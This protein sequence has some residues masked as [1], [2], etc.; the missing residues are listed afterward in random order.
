MIA[1]MPNLDFEG[2][3]P[4]WAGN[5][6][7]CQLFNSFSVLLIRLEP[8]MNR[9]M[10]RAKDELDPDDPLRDEIDVF[11]K[12]EANH[13][14]V[15][16]RFNQALYDSGYDELKNIEKRMGKDYSAFFESRPL[17]DQAAY[18]EGFEVLGP[19][20]A[21]LFFEEID[22][23]LK[24]GDRA[25]VDLWKWH[26]AEEYEHRMVA[27][28]VLHRLGG[29]WLTRLRGV[30]TTTKH[31][32]FYRRMILRHLNEVDRASMSDEEIARSRASARRLNRRILMFGLRKALPLLSPFY[33]PARKPQPRGAARYLA[34]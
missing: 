19:L 8:Y 20:L 23:L 34:A 16:R 31:L 28:E 14:L 4:I 22:D 29:T 33:S 3:L 1:R 24:D 32:G 26:L 12:Q 17:V 6:E 30:Y 7:F 15:H 18:C 5:R 2:S 13:T 25:V 10:R 9:V 11:V 21:Q 27:F